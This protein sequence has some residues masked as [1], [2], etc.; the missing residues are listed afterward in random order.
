MAFYQV[1]WRFT[2][3]ILR[4]QEDIKVLLSITNDNRVIDVDIGLQALACSIFSH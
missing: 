4:I 1:K 3:A 2:S